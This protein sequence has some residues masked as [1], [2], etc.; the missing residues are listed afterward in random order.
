[1][2]DGLIGLLA[3]TESFYYFLPNSV[4]LEIDSKK[5]TFLGQLLSRYHMLRLFQPFFVNILLIQTIDGKL[6][7]QTR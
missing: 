7:I 3:L 1:M 2:L 6:H 5:L 4:E